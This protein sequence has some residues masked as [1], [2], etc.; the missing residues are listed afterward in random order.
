MLDII[1]TNRQL[2]KGNFLATI[3]KALIYKP[4]A[5]ILREKDLPR[6]EYITLASKVNSLCKAHAVPL[7]PHTHA[8]PGIPRLHLPFHLANK[9]LAEIHSLSLSIHSIEEA[10]LAEGLGA[11]FVIAGHIFATQSKPGLPP[12]GLDFLREVCAS[13]SIPVFAIGGVDAHNAQSC[14]NAGAVGLCKMSYWMQTS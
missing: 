9:E 6:D 5:I 10:R 3:E 12:R 7:I 8:V 4:Y 2:C 13:V 1:V 14:I 11:A